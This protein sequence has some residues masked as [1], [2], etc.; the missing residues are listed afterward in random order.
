MQTQHR[1]L[2]HERRSPAVKMHFKPFSGLQAPP[3]PAG[4]ITVFPSPRIHGSTE[5]SDHSRVTSHPGQ[6]SLLP[7]VGWEMSAGQEAAA[8]LFDVGLALHASQAQ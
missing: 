8:E 7:S 1:R 3:K 4:Q 6:L 5:M 2:R